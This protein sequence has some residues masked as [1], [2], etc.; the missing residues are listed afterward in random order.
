MSI[1]A[2]NHVMKF[3]AGGFAQ[4]VL[5]FLANSKNEETGKCNPSREAIAEFFSSEDDPCSVKRV[6]RA[7]AKLRKMG[8]ITSERVKCKSGVMNVY[9]FPG[10]DASA[11]GSSQDDI[12]P[13]VE[14]SPHSGV[15][16]TM[17]GSPHGGQ[18]SDPQWG[19]RVAPT[20]GAGNRNKKQE[21]ETGKVVV[22]TAFADSPPPPTED[23]LAA[24]QG[25][26]FVVEE[27]RSVKPTPPAEEEKPKKKRAPL[28]TLPEELP[29]DWR[30]LAQERRPEIDSDELLAKMRTYYGPL[31]K[32]TLANWKRTFINWLAKERRPI[33]ANNRSYYRGEPQ[34]TPED[35]ASVD[36]SQGTWGY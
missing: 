15:D 20:V 3:R 31:E 30:T 7:L 34:P 11:G 13:T 18:G 17:G 25:E 27:Q 26:L 6:D 33:Y 19:R 22:S 36:Y 16:P 21:I 9:R 32:K 4:A 8:A 35:W 23:D 5:L 1:A 10:L 2:L 29:D 12:N 24:M 28:V 14:G